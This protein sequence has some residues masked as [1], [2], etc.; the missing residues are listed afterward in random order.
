[1]T[2]NSISS[3]HYI[4]SMHPGEWVC[5]FVEIFDMKG[6]FSKGRGYETMH[7]LMGCSTC[8]Q[9]YFVYIEYI[10]K[11]NSTWLKNQY[12]FEKLNETLSFVAPRFAL[13]HQLK[14]PS[15]HPFGGGGS[16]LVEIYPFEIKGCFQR[17]GGH[18]TMLIIMGYSI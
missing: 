8:I 12:H 10:F 15:T 6:Y 4:P 16:F 17:G 18:E 9:E 5:S 7:I 13:E 14:T 2:C 1:M 11:I 3:Y